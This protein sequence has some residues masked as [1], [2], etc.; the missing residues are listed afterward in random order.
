MAGLTNRGKKL[1]F[2]WVFRGVALPANFFLALVTSADV[3]DADTN[4]FSEL[5]EIATGNG[6]TTGGY[7]LTPGTTDFDSLTEDDAAN[8]ARLQMKDIAWTASG[9][10]IPSS[11]T[12]ARYAVLLD[13]N[14]TVGSR[15]VIGFWDLTSNR[16]VSS[17][18]TFTLK[19]LE[20]DCTE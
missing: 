13:D 10:P 18:Q 6:Y 2:D 19:D 5:T 7:S 3:P 16:S 14:A 17:G 8:E 1:L 12:G 11:G 4:T 9:G 20:M 15:Q